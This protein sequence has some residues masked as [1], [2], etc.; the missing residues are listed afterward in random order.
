[1]FSWNKKTGRFDLTKNPNVVP[2][3]LEV[4]WN[5]YHSG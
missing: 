2:T 5:R 1:M 4:L 3:A